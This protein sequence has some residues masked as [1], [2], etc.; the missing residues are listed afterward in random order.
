M[1]AGEGDDLTV[2]KDQED[3]MD[4]DEYIQN[5]LPE[6]EHA[7]IAQE[8]ELAV[9]AQ[10]QAIA[11]RASGGGDGVQ[12]VQAQAAVAGGNGHAQA[13]A[14]DADDEVLVVDPPPAV[15][16]APAHPPSFL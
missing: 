8:Q 11:A 9:Q 15:P 1:I 6:L 13:Q 12:P 10:A 7:A 2:Q 4:I 3:P 16:A 5:V 14:T